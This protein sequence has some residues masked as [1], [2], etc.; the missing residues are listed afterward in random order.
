MTLYGT[1]VKVCECGGNMILDE[2][3]KLLIF[4]PVYKGQCNKCCEIKYYDL[5]GVPNDATKR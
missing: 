2:S 5:T 3:I 1:S 4:P